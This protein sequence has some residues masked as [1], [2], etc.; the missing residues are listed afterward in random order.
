VDPADPVDA[1]VLASQ[2]SGHNGTRQTG[3]GHTGTASS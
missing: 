2:A 3:T 1:M